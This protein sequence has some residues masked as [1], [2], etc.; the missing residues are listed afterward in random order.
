MG[1]VHEK[2]THQS[3]PLDGDDKC[4]KIVQAPQLGVITGSYLKTYAEGVTTY[5]EQRGYS[6]VALG[7][8]VIT[9]K[10]DTKEM[11]VR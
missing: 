6:P 1:H 7:A 8:A 10:P 3:V 11:E 2:M 5:G 4:S 9:I